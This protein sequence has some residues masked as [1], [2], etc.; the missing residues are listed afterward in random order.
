MKR[1]MKL[2]TIVGARPQF[3][4]VAPLARCLREH[5]SEHKLLH[6]GQHYD[7]EMSKIFFD[8]LGLPEPNYYSGVG[9]GSHG[10]QTGEIMKRVERVLLQEKPDW[11]LVYGD[12]N[13]TLAGALAA[14]KLYIP[15]AH[16]EAGLRS[17][18]RRM[19]EE[20]NR[21]LTDHVS[22]LLCCP[23]EVAVANLKSEGFTNIASEGRLLP[24]L[25]AVRDPKVASG[26]S[27]RPLVANTGDI[28]YD[29]FLLCQELAA[30]KSA[31]IERLGLIPKGYFLATVHR[32]GNTDTVEP[33]TKIVEA[34]CQLSLIL[35]VIWVIHP[36]TRK[37]LDANGL[38]QRVAAFPRVRPIPPVGYFDMLMLE[39]G[40]AAIFTD[41]GGVQKEAYFA[42]VPCITLREE[43]EWVELVQHGFNRLVG[44]DTDKIITSGRKAVEE[45]V[46]WNDWLYGDG[47]TAN[48][49]LA[50]LS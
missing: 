26:H 4:K 23:T 40:A 41:S 3:I 46:T 49:I 30:T 27:S 2:V 19:P 44:T 22:Q 17:Y 18:N 39:Q 42:R 47:N 38:S 16:I 33:L 25:E 5:P 48:R 31:V 34:F 50:I 36:R 14:A 9:S 24:E 11:V 28:M 21:V 10:E 8:E 7:Y 13:S 29:V 43:T 12:T 15:V 6:T 20:I 1:L 35:P 37:A 32:A 45:K